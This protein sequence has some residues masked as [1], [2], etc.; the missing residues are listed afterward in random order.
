MEGAFIR[1]ID[2]QLFLVGAYLGVGLLFVGG[3]LCAYSGGHLF[4][5]E[6][7]FVEGC[8]FAEGPYS[9]E[10]AYSGHGTYS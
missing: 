9:R 7:I 1:R 10:N 3:R 2:G 8:L 4:L 6:R 5:I